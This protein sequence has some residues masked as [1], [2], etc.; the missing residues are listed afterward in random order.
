MYAHT[1]NEPPHESIDP[2]GPNSFLFGI[3]NVSEPHSTQQ[4]SNLVKDKS[5]VRCEEQAA[6]IAAQTL[7]D[8]SVL[9]HTPT[10]FPGSGFPAGALI[11][12]SRFQFLSFPHP[13]VLERKAP[14]IAVFPTKRNSQLI[15]KKLISNPIRQT[16]ISFMTLQAI[17][18]KS[19]PP[20]FGL[21]KA[22]QVFT[23]SRVVGVGDMR[24]PSDHPPRAA[25]P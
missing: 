20:S 3:D 21:P 18:S 25:S 7:L 10:P 6:E 17:G 1:K 19:L 16:E 24:L 13:F 15:F 5:G 2:S 22:R 4:S 8:P 11:V 14:S 23:W 12:Q 9:H